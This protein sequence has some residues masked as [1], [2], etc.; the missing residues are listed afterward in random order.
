MNKR[1]VCK[2]CGADSIWEKCSACI[3]KE[4]T[5]DPY[6][7]HKEGDS[8]CQCKNCMN[9]T[10]RQWE[11]EPCIMCHKEKKDCE[12]ESKK[13]K[14]KGCVL[15]AENRDC[16]ADRGGIESTSAWSSGDIDSI[17]EKECPNCKKNY[18]DYKSTSGSHDPQEKKEYEEEHTY[19]IDWDGVK[20]K[21]H[22][23]LSALETYL[24]EHSINSITLE[25]S[26]WIIK[27]KDNK[28]TTEDSENVP[29]LQ[30]A[31]NYLSDKQKKTISSSELSNIV[32]QNSSNNDNNKPTSYWPWILGI[33][34][35]LALGGIIIYFLTKKKEK[36][37]EEEYF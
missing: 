25:N 36:K 33:G 31:K 17:C 12:A 11:L 10:L 3:D 6:K 37:A 8:L 1:D 19:V 15:L 30:A 18:N 7:E 27:H 23:C 4:T 26:K 22:F 5:Y 24:Q 16:G 13:W 28:L 32:L 20:R 29:E 34:G 2:T 35:I 9:E 21:E 14:V